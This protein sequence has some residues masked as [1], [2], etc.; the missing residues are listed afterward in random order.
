M[1][2]VPRIR[3]TEKRLCL[4]FLPR[5]PCE[6]VLLFELARTKKWQSSPRR[7]PRQL[8]ERIRL[9]PMWAERMGRVR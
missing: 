2:L 4:H 9:G 7:C 1:E 8:K 6:Y 3:S 5:S